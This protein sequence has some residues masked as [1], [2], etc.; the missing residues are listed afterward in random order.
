M[1]TSRV[2][3]SDLPPPAA[4]RQRAR[5]RL[6]LPAA[7]GMGALGVGAAWVLL[8][9]IWFLTNL[10][11][12]HRLSAAYAEAHAAPGAS[13]PLT[14]LLLCAS[15][16]VAGLAIRYGHESLRGHGI[17]EVMEAVLRRQGRI[18]ARVAALKP[19][20]S[21]LVIGA[22]APFGAEGPIIQ[23]GGALGSLA[24]QMLPVSTAERTAL[25][26]CGAAAGMTGVFGTPLAAV[27]LPIELLTFE[28]SLRTVAPVAIAAAVAAALRGPLLGMQPLFAM[29]ASPGA[30]PVGLLWCLVFGLGAGLEAVGITRALYGLEHAYERLPGPGAIVRPVVGALGVG[31]IALAGPQV[32]GV[33]YDIIRN[34]LNGSVG[35]A[36]LWRILILKASGWLLA[37]ASGTVGGVL[38]PLFMIAGATGALVGH[39]VHAWSGLPPALVALV[40]MA[41]VFGAASRAVLTAAIF[42][43]EVT[44]DFHALPAVLLA[45]GLATAVAERLLPYN[46]MTGKL[47][48]RGLAVPLDYFAPG[49][50]P[51]RGGGGG[52]G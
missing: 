8:R 47:A 39:A 49:W 21:A 9:L 34:I 40:F 25:I 30:G 11:Y 52:D 1:I 51:A 13:G 45:T 28:F 6:L 44:G 50:Q 33:G 15:A 12:W 5:F 24:G 37:L 3:G 43:A 4:P 18:P 38:A 2:P 19:L 17:P 41:A 14:I 20:V 29:T 36:R 10:F 26:A 32:L 16:A 23:T 35:V 46:V 48:R 31:L 27:L 22:G 42:A 7:A